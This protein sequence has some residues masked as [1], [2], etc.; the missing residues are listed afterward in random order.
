MYATPVPYLEACRWAQVQDF[1]FRLTSLGCY[2]PILID[3]HFG[4]NSLLK[5]A[6]LKLYS[7]KKA[8]HL[9]NDPI[10]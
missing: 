10:I 2:L 7:Y 1:S 4:K 8:V 5:R 3:T 9:G 6:H